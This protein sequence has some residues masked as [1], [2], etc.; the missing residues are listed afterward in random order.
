M[1]AFQGKVVLITGGTT[2]IGRATAVAFAKEGAK[3]VV[4][5]RREPE[6]QETVGL[7]KAAG[8]DGLFVR[9]DVSK[10]ADVKAMIEAVLKAYGRLDA[11]F[12]NAGVEQD[13]GPLTETTEA[14][15]DQVMD[16]NVKG[17]FLS[18]KHEIPAMLRTG[19]G[20]IINNSSVAGLV[21]LANVPV[22]IASKH[23]VTGMTKAVALEYA[24]QGIRV[25]AVAP[26]GVETP[27]LDRFLTKI[28]K[29]ALEA[30]H[31]V[32]RLGRPEEIAAAV[33]FL[34]SPSAGFLT[35]QTVAVDG[36]WTA[37]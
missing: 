36:G 15:Y 33:L 19:G 17:V 14:V 29:A 22:Y 4:S 9:A 16:I 3:V 18:M 21:G 5:G 8:G 23:A 7:I 28:P 34:A 32:G 1:S 13:P 35:G 6:G 2:G 10:E 30:A 37:Q 26:G 27:M 11:A 25:N 20:A 24:K 31:P 12:N